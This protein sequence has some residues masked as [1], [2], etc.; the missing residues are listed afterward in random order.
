[1]LRMAE[2]TGRIFN[3]EKDTLVTMMAA[4]CDEG[5]KLADINCVAFAGWLGE[6]VDLETMSRKWYSLLEPLGVEYIKMSEVLGYR[7]EFQGWKTRKVERDR[8]MSDLAEIGYQHAACFIGAPMPCE[9]FKALPEA[10]RRKLRNPQYCGFETFVRVMAEN[11]AAIG[12]QMQLWCDS[13]EEFAE[14][15]LSLYHRLRRRNQLVKDTC[16]SIVFGED[17]AF[18]PLQLADVYASCVRQ[19]AMRRVTKPDPLI[20]KLLE[21]LGRG[22]GFGGSMTYRPNAGLG[23]GIVRPGQK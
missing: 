1:M 21:I 2:T 14:V 19:D 5:G 18:P 15:C 20:D 17:Q 10:H 7:G 9:D 11:T 4:C 8:L 6:M 22:G 23:H 16:V 3:H 13:T 12:Q